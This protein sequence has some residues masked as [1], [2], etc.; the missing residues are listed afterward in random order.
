MDP[1]GYQRFDRHG[2]ALKAQVRHVPSMPDAKVYLA[3]SIV[4]MPPGRKSGSIFFWC[5]MKWQLK[6]GEEE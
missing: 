3:L 2:D 6:N 5:P 4:L 1:M